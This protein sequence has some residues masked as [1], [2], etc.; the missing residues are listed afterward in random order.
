MV[1]VAIS[2]QHNWFCEYGQPAPEQDLNFGLLWMQ[3]VGA[4]HSAT[5]DFL[6]VRIWIIV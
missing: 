5:D 1:L 6:T 2:N 4:Y 3:K